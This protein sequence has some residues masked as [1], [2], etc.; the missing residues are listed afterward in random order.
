LDNDPAPKF[1]LNRLVSYDE[2]SLIAELQRIAGLVPDQ[3]LSGKKFCSLARVNASTLR[4][5]FGSWKAALELAGLAHRLD[6]SNQPATPEEIITEMQRVAR[7]LATATLT[8]QLF[9]ANSPY[10]LRPVVRLFGSWPAGLKAAGLT[11]SNMGKRYTDEQCFENMLT[12]WTYYGRPPQHREMEKPPSVVGAKPYVTRWGTWL[13]A[14]DAFATLA[15]MDDSPTPP[16]PDQPEQEGS[17]VSGPA[18]DPRGPRDIALSIRYKV[19]SR[20]R[21]RCVTCGR[22]PAT[23]PEIS[24]HVDHIMPW[25]KG[26]AT[27]L[28]NI[29]AL[30]EDCNLGKGARLEDVARV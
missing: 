21:F 6:P 22:S 30:C 1:E 15:N 10:T 20:D 19:L 5:R 29:R 28:A 3:Y 27:T 13:R 2:A 9:E 12:V 14:L 25:S 23:H 7:L 11:V 18:P 16:R 8:R 26:G 24:L 17:T 4:K